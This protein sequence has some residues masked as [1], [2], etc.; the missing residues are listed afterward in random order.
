MITMSLELV[1]SAEKRRSDRRSSEGAPYT[2]ADWTD[3]D[4]SS[5]T[6]YVRSKTLAEQA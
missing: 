6:P 5:R 3:G 4:D 2:E 1:T